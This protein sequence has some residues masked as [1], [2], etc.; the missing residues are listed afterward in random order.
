MLHMGVASKRDH[1]RLGRTQIRGAE[2]LLGGVVGGLVYLPK[3]T[4]SGFGHK[5]EDR[6]R[7]VTRKRVQRSDFGGQQ[8]RA[9]RYWAR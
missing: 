4:D 5:Y 9:G 7:S 3:W 8:Y 6:H 1:K 2:T